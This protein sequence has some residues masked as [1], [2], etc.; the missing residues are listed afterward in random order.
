[1]V[2]FVRRG[3]R[4]QGKQLAAW[5]RLSGHYLVDV[6]RASGATSVDP[7]AR[8][9]APATF[10]RRAPLTVEIGSGLG[11]AVVAAAAAAPE[12]DFLALDVY[13][14]GLSDL[15]RKADTAGAP[16]IRVIEANAPEVFGTL[17][18][19]GSV[20]EVWMF[21]PDP[22]PK[23][24]HHKRRLVSPAFA[25]L[26]ARVLRPGGRWRLAT[27]WEEYAEQMRATLDEVPAFTPANDGPDG[28][29]P[30]FD[31]RIET[32]FERKGIAAGRVIRDLTYIRR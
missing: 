25:E 24:R 14:P 15:M 23:K 8:L 30:R 3:T 28:W 31:G 5:E 2:S 22:W 19:P 32:G 18:A 6:S 13:R 20:D 11:D 10:G 1:M 29:A 26:V 4:L 16:N 9:D 27:D 7:G 17:L 12:R 21:F